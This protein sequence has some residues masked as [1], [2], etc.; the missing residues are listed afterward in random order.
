VILILCSIILAG[1]GGLELFEPSL[2]AVMPGKDM[3]KLLIAMD[4]NYPPYA[5]VGK[6]P[7]SSLSGF[8]VDFI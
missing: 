7:E 1:V 3:P 8:N 6:P 5:S 2:A 4:V